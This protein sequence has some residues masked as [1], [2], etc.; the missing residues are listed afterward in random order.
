MPPGSDNF[1]FTTYSGANGS[2]NVLATFTGNFTI[3]AGVAN[4]NTATLLGVPKTFTIS[5]VPGGTAGTSFGR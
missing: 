3:S 5:G 2:G 4:S 1:T